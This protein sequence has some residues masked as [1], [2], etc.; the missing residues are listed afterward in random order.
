MLRGGA[1]GDFR[2][3]IRN[4]TA[5]G[6]TR[7][8]AARPDPQTA[9][10][11]WTM[12]RGSAE[13][14]FRAARRHSRVV[15]ILRI[16][17]PL[18]MV[19]ALT[20]VTFITY[21]NPLRMLAKLPIDVGNLV[22]SGTKITME[23]PRLSGFTSDG[24]AYEVTAVAAAQDV[25]KPNIVELHDIHAKV[26]MQNHGTVQ[27]TAATGIYDTKGEILKLAQDIVLTSSTGYE[28]RMSEAVIDTRK[29]NVVSEHPVEVKMLQGTLNANRLEVVDSGDLVRFDGGVDMMLTLK[30][31]DA[32]QNKAGGQ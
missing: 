32:S 16:A 9:R 19:L 15:R 10:A 7:V 20:V 30:E 21:F 1:S 8:I 6:M 25:T 29:G 4:D 23:Q 27:M 22:I 24:R 26:Q 3:P 14:A 11:Y 2:E 12:S 18:T 28:C 13:R 31:P 5:S 17:L